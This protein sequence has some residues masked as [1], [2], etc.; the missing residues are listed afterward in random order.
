M[1]TVSILILLASLTSVAS[2]SSVYEEVTELL[3]K[4]RTHCLKAFEEH[5]ATYQFRERSKHWHEL[6]RFGFGKVPALIDFVEEE[7]HP[8]IRS[9]F[10]DRLR[11]LLGF[12]FYKY[13]FKHSEPP[14]NC[15]DDDI[16]WMP[17]LREQWGPNPDGSLPERQDQV[18]MLLTWVQQRDTFLKREGVCERL[19]EITGTDEAAYLAFDHADWRKLFKETC[20]YGVYNLPYVIQLIGQDNNAV[21]FTEGGMEC[22]SYEAPAAGPSGFPNERVKNVNARFPTLEEKMCAGG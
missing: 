8:L 13:S 3:E 14:Y 22:G 1:R 7:T 9:E 15:F 18:E 12:Q 11:M 6:C 19:R 17:F 2:A 20:A 16:E 4:E 5:P 21:V 10:A